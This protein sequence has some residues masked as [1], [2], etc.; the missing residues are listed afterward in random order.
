[1]KVGTAYTRLLVK[2]WKACFLFYKEVIEFD[3]AVVDEEAGYAEFKAGEMRLTLFRRQEMAQM[4][5]NADQPAHAE[6]QDTVALIFVVQDLEEEYQRLR[7]KGVHF[8]AAPMN[9]PY[10]NLK[11]AYLRDPDGTLIGLYQYLV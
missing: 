9:N 8:T 1:M 6:C 5:H 10:Y 2:D 4:I 11:T 3:V 7:H